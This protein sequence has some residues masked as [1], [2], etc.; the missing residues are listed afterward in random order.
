M[1]G[2][3]GIYTKERIDHG[4]VKK[5]TEILNHRGPDDTGYYFDD[6]IAL[7]KKD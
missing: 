1:C 5:A 4:Q 7:G 2:I 6:Q 3:L